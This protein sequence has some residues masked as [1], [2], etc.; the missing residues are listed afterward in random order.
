L[1]TF[2]NIFLRNLLLFDLLILLFFS[3]SKELVINCSTKNANKI[4]NTNKKTKF[5]IFKN[6]NLFC[7]ITRILSR[8][9]KTTIEL[10]NSKSRILLK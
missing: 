8:Y 2:A 9:S 4:K 10:K 5:K 3:L 7:Y 6:A 1:L